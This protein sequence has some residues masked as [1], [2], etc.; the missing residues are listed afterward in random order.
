[1]DSQNFDKDI[2]EALKVLRNGGIIL[3]PTDTVWG[4]GCDATNEKAVERIYKLKM[5][6][7]SKSMIILLGDVGMIESFTAPLP[8]I[9]Y[10]LLDSI[11]EPTT[12]IYDGA[13][14]IAKNL[15]AED[16]SIAIRI[17]NEK[18][19]Q[20]L[21]KRFRKPLVSTSA[22]LA[23]KDTPAIY[24]QIDKNIIDAVDYVVQYRQNDN[25][26]AKPS[27]IIKLTSQGRVKVI[28]T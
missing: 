9:A 19:S 16:N 26:S 23:G 5:R 3:Y 20:T 25:K 13:K 17:T 24:K 12:I 21:A 15:I 28:R 27:A 14:N 22:N 10:E 7:N 1:M 8:N 18:Y 11:V 2:E 6:E 4:L